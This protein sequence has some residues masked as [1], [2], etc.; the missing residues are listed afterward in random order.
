[1]LR[2]CLVACSVGLLGLSGC[3]TRR[4]H[5]DRV[6]EVRAEMEA[7]HAKSIGALTE[8]LRDAEQG[9]GTVKKELST[10]QAGVKKLTDQLAKAQKERDGYRKQC[11][12]LQGSLVGQLKGMPDVAVDK[13]GALKASG[14]SFELGG[15]ELQ[16]DSVKTVKTLAAALAKAPGRIYVDGHTDNVPV[17]NPA[18]RRRFQDNLGLSLA[19][20]AAVAR[21]L[22]EAD[23]PAER[24]VVRG[25]G[26]ARPIAPNKTREGR[27]KNRRVEI[28][29]LPPGK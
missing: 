9:V 13:T 10:A 5:E 20:A 3:V 8:K 11:E 18:T 25:F 16:P 12:A 2:V 4:A 29:L 22:M 23:I 24:L 19:R 21:V 1:M 17:G 7:A 15:V 28:R 26:S 6:A 14:F 27:A